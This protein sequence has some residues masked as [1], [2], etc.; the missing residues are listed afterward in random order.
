ME[1][2]YCTSAVY[3][4]WS[5]KNAKT[6]EKT[7]KITLFFEIFLIE[8]F[9]EIF[10]HRVGWGAQKKFPS[11]RGQNFEILS[12]GLKILKFH[13]GIH[14]ENKIRFILATLGP[15]RWRDSTAQVQCILADLDFLRFLENI[16]SHP[17]GISTPVLSTVG[18]VTNIYQ[19]ITC[20][21]VIHPAAGFVR[22]DNHLHI[23]TDHR[24]SCDVPLYYRPRTHVALRK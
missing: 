8:I 6:N 16:L 12:R 19:P 10:F 1:R 11:R 21:H 18:H 3:F 17:D 2:F 22:S 9:F 23:L 13:R 20:M 15:N 5:R 7:P 4:N 14:F 24:H